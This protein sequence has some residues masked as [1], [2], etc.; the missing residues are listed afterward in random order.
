MLREAAAVR[1][2]LR[3]L[4]DSLGRL[5]IRESRRIL[6]NSDWGIAAKRMI[7]LL[8]QDRQRQRTT[9]D[10]WQRWAL[11]VYGCHAKAFNQAFHQRPCRIKKKKP[12]PDTW[13]AASRLMREAIKN[14]FYRKTRLTGWKTWAYKHAW[15]RHYLKMGGTKKNRWLRLRRC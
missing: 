8:N 6:D 2:Q 12:E 1:T 3:A 10:T 7:G 4:A 15:E 14:E 5:V 11:I 13:I 9:A